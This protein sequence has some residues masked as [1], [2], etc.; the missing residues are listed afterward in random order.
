M[1]PI[2]RPSYIMYVYWD[3]RMDSRARIATAENSFSI[4]S[5]FVVYST[6]HIY[7]MS[8]KKKTLTCRVWL[9]YTLC[10]QVWLI[11]NHQGRYRWIGFPVA[12]SVVIE[13]S[14]RKSFFYFISFYLTF[15]FYILYLFLL[16]FF[17]LI[18]LGHFFA[19]RA[20]P[21]YITRDDGPFLTISEAHSSCIRNL[22]MHL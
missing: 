3:G 13:H 5:T 15:L 12:V 11:G 8:G 10:L 16:F 18:V 6:F 19:L 22:L 4:R 14:G 7:N 17:P 21:F 2:S 1:A 9:A 20:A